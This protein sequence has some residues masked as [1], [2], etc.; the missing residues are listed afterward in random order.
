M[1]TED[2]TTGDKDSGQAMMPGKTTQPGDTAKEPIPGDAV[3]TSASAPLSAKEPHPTIAEHQ[4]E[5]SGSQSGSVKARIPDSVKDGANKLTA[6]ATE[7]AR[8]A[9]EEGKAQ[10]SQTVRSLASST[11]EAA[12]QFEGTQ[13]EM[14]TSY[15]TGAAD[16]IDSFAGQLDEKSV[17][18]LLDD[19]REL[20]RRSPAIAIGAAATVG[21]MISRFAK[22]TERGELTATPSDRDVSARG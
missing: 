12:K 17:D 18:E 10:A 5:G 14:L 22:A 7:R 11:R 9:A 4:G 19:F 3:Q 13:A 6:Q 2:N 15:I 16:S 8:G 20:V 1:P 21:F